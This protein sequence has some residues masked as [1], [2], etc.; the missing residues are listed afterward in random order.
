MRCVKECFDTISYRISRAITTHYSTSFS[1]G[2]KLLH[3]SLRNDIYNIYGFVRLADEIVDSFHGFDQKDLLKC[4]RNDTEAAIANKISINPALNSFQYTVNKHNIPY[5]L[6]KSF[7][8]SMEMD[9][10][11]KTYDKAAYDEYIFGSAEVVGLMCLCVF[12]NGDGEKYDELKPFAQKLGSAF[13]K[14]NF[15]RDIQCDT[16]VL[17]RRYFPNLNLVGITEAD[18]KEIEKEIED[19][20]LEAFR[21]IKMLPNTSRKGVYIAYI[22]YRQ[23]LKKVKATSAK[24]LCKR[25][26]RVSNFEKMTLILQHQIFPSI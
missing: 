9:L 16:N 12:C 1:V 23:L 26:L 7:L 2:I 8:H 22:Y 5:S 3:P 11:K 4:F 20:F 13:Q 10:Y 17:G 25:R 18:K 24:E 19:E 21:G 6:V 15:L 14:V